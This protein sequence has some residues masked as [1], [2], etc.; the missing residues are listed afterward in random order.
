MGITLK[1]KK[2][3]PDPAPASTPAPAPNKPE[4]S[5]KQVTEAG[6]KGTREEQRIARVKEQVGD[7]KEIRVVSSEVLAKR[8][9]A[10]MKD[11]VVVDLH[12][13]FYRG[14]QRLDAAALGLNGVPAEVLERLA[15]GHIRLLPQDA[16]KQLGNAESAAR[17]ALNAT[18]IRIGSDHFVP[19]HR[20]KKFNT[21]FQE[22]KERFWKAVKDVTNNLDQVIKDTH[23]SLRKLAP[24]LW[25]NG[26]NKTWRNGEMADLQ[27]PPDEFCQEFANRIVA[28]IPT[29]PEIEDKARFEYNL[30]LYQLP[31]TQL[32]ADYATGDEKL[33]DQV[34]EHM[35]A[36][37]KELIDEFLNS[38]RA[39]LAE[40]LMKLADHVQTKCAGRD[41]V[42]KT[43]IKHI[44]ATLADLEDIN[45]LNDDE[46]GEAITNLKMF[47][48]S[49]DGT[50]ISS[51]EMQKQ[52]QTAAEKV[53]AAIKTELRV[54][55]QFANL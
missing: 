20:F 10:A 53:S 31:D 1:M 42:H 35:S 51:H 26:E 21:I 16:V 27:N 29:A 43:T 8:T 15:L 6:H 40:P 24:H 19:A 25:T 11:G 55:Q 3:S 38:A 46:I 9:A 13:G 45:V 47:V 12:V 34:M 30:R 14:K 5:L 28:E 4:P 22:E 52:M 33:H 48:E 49:R 32:A 54:D 36:K 37:K 2:S 17:A 23:E 44:M 39:G 41:N 18:A 7:D 50:K